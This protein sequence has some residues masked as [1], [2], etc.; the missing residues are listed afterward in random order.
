MSTHDSDSGWPL[1]LVGGAGLVCLLLGG[2]GYY[3]FGAS[4]SV[5]QPGEEG[6]EIASSFLD[7]VREKKWTAAWDQTGP[8]FRSYMGLETFK[9]YVAKH[10]A[11]KEKIEYKGMN[12]RSVNGLD[13][14]EFHFQSSQS[15]K[16][17]DIVLAPDQGRFKV[18][19]FE[20]E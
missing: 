1:G 16:K 7:Q 9:T 3:W 4:G 14:V 13:R 20:S 8:E 5:A 17:I 15:A 11:L 19:H 10:P 12:K 6:K 18:E 2:A